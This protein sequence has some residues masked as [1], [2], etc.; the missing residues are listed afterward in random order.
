M[1]EIN[2]SNSF[3]VN[4]RY[5]RKNSRLKQ[6]SQI[7]TLTDFAA[8]AEFSQTRVGIGHMARTTADYGAAKAAKYHSKN[9]WS[10]GLYT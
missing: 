6:T 9:E 10:K 1:G 5:P 3:W 7:G 4:A 8:N 2:G